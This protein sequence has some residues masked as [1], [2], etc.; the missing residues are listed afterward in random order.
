MFSPL[1]VFPLQ[2][3]IFQN[4]QLWLSEILKSNIMKRNCLFLMAIIAITVSSCSKEELASNDLMTS[5]QTNA[6]TAE[7]TTGTVSKL[8][9]LPSGT[10]YGA[11]IDASDAS[12][13]YTFTTNVAATLGLSCLRD[14]A[15]VGAAKKV[16]TLSSQYNILLNFTSTGVMPMKFRTD[17][18]TY[19]ADLRTTI[20]SLSSMPKIAVI[21]NEESNK[22]YYSASAADY[23]TE[24][25]A[26]IT[27]MHSYGIPVANGGITSTGLNYLV[28]QDYMNRGMTTQANDFK[29][30]MKVGINSTTTKDRAAFIQVLITNF[31]TMDIDYVNFHWYSNSAADAQGLGEAIDYLKRATGKTVI[32][33]EIGQYDQDPVTL[34]STVQMCKNYAFPFVI[35]YSGDEGGRS[36]PLQYTNE[37]L[38]T[39]GVAY[40][41][42]IATH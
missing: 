16:K 12:D 26:A 22:N 14:V 6:A 10:N 30:R 33:N 35:W 38:T 4:R 5:S 19:Q 3:P 11:L 13:S 25:K 41:G 36:Y 20:N 34:T 7:T 29:K 32:T 40:Q 28:W 17:V 18:T 21:E 2:N 39:S 15:P 1:F 24:L 42:F 9:L 31:V 8:L 27:V 37:L 23:I